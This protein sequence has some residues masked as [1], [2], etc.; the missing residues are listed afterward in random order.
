[1]VSDLSELLEHACAVLA[2]RLGLPDAVDAHDADEASRSPG[3]HAGERNISR[4]GFSS[5]NP[6]S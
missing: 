5:L 3:G 2:Q 4:R 6:R 1:M